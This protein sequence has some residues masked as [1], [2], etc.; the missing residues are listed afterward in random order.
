MSRRSKD[1]VISPEV[2]IPPVWFQGREYQRELWDF[3]TGGGK[4]AVIQ[5]HRRAGKDLLCLMLIAHMA[6]R[7]VGTYWHIFPTFADGKKAIWNGITNDGFR[8]TNAFPM[9]LI[10]TERGNELFYRFKNGSVYQMIGASEPD[11]LRG[12]N[13]VGFIYSEYAYMN[14]HISLVLD[15]VIAANDAWQVWISTPRGTNHFTDLLDIAEEEQKKDPKKWFAQTLTIEDTKK[16]DGT[17]VVPLEMVEIERKK[18]KD[19]WAIQREYYCSRVAPV[20]GSYYGNQINDAVEQGRIGDV[21][22][23]PMYPVHTAWDIAFGKSDYCAIW[24]FQIIGNKI[25][26]IDYYHN[27]AE[28]L[29]HYVKK[30]KEKPYIYGVHI[31]PHDLAKSESE[32]TIWTNACK[33]GIKFKVLQKT[34]RQSGVEELRSVFPRMYFNKNTTQKGVSCLKNYR[35]ASVTT[36]DGDEVFL[37]SPEKSEATHG[38]DAARYVSMGLKEFPMAFLPQAERKIQKTYRGKIS[39]EKRTKPTR[40]AKYG[41]NF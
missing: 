32:G 10:E 7:K 13:A 20:E 40:L 9:E 25:H 36:D 17:P 33:H 28:G 1:L 5:W 19:E 22:W 8:Y 29:L 11:K 41:S 27:Q 16:E 15:P 26:M 3:I 23:D 4:N 2:Q 12:T 39:I 24:F 38:A 34:S 37:D 18:G 31:G 14:K 35:K 30:V 6:M 21:P